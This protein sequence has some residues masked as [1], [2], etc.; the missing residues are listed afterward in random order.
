MS[1]YFKPKSVTWW[2]GMVPLVAGIVVAT[3][4]L[5]GMTSVVLA[6]DTITEGASPAAMINAG[7]AA[8]GFRGAIGQKAGE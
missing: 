6:I 1:K 4:S 8:I 5:H 7:L 3:E 2:A